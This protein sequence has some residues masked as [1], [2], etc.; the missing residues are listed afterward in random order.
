[1]IDEPDPRNLS[2][3]VR[4][5]VLSGRVPLAL[6]EELAAEADRLRET[7]EKIKEALEWKSS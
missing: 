1:M 5:W 3:A 6:C 7:V 4:G 2:E